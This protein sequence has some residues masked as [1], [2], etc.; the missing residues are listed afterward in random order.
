MSVETE[1]TINEAIHDAEAVRDP[2]DDLVEKAAKDAGAPFEPEILELLA[3]LRKE[4]PAD[5]HRLRA[6]LKNVGIRVTALEKAIAE[7]AGETG[8]HG[9]TQANILID[10]A[11]AAELFHTP[12]STGYADLII[13]D[14]RETWPLRSKG[15][16]RWL[17]QRYY[18]ETGGAPNSEAMQ[19]ALGLIEA[20]AHFESPEHKIHIR[21]AGFDNKIYIDLADDK[22]QAIEIDTDGWRVITNP[23]VRFRRAAGM[24]PLVIPQSGGSIEALH[25]F[26]NVQH[27]DDFVLVVA[28]LL[29]ALRD[30]GPYPPLVLAGEQG[31]AKST[32][33]AIIRALFDPSTTPLRALPRE[34]RDLFVAASNGHLLAFDNV[35]GLPAWIS[36]TLCRLATGGGFAVRQLYTD[37]DEVLFDATRP[38]I[39]NGIEDIVTRPDLA[40]RAIFLILQP[41]PDEKRKSEKELWQEFEEKR[42]YII[43]ALLDAVVHGLKML[44]STRLE[45]SPRMADFALW[46]AAC[47]G[48]LWEKDTFI[49]A[50]TGNRDEAIESVTDADPVASAVRTLMAERTHWTGTATTLLG[51]LV[52]IVGET[53]RKS[54]TWPDTPKVLS[55]RLRRAAPF[56]RKLRIWI[57]FERDK[58]KARS[59]TIHIKVMDSPGNFASAPS[60]ASANDTT[61]AA[62]ATDAEIPTQTNPQTHNSQTWAAEV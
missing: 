38:I 6:K 22:W 17:A 9:A 62:D 34:D 52:D 20:R 27:D 1:T 7:E 16:K 39:L 36:D 58:G 8:A 2:L 37:Q 33:C 4:R 40:D 19:S 15:F 21:V 26:L 51:V 43:G 32:F 24:L 11:S 14:H 10:L 57:E 61:T 50:Y 60:D 44:P 48:A 42:P 23:P 31:T 41:I 30:H 55:G 59:R 3:K 47:E 56:L 29:A 25:D 18:K 12:D 45:K 54:K 49:N 5:Y 46:G 13:D 35:S 53:I 28:W